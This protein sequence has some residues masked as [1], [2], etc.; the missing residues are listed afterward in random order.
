MPG[1]EARLIEYSGERG[2]GLQHL[3]IL[4]GRQAHARIWPQIVSW[5]NLAADRLGRMP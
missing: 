3:A 4:V 1:P 2:V 5:L